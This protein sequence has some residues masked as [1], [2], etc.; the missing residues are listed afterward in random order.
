MKTEDY[1]KLKKL[2]DANGFELLSESPKENDKF[3]V[4]KKKPERVR[5]EYSGSSCTR[6]EL[7]SNYDKHIYTFYVSKKIGLPYNSAGSFL[8]EQYEQYL[9]KQL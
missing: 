8:A 5:V 1:D 9:N 2:C 7:N 3:Y 6:H 4:V